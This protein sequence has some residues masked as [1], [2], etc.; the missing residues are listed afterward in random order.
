M[1]QDQSD[2]IGS[3][4]LEG[5]GWYEGCL[6]KKLEEEEEG[7]GGERYEFTEEQKSAKHPIIWGKWR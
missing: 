3:Q 1:K 7:K 4:H 2:E 6:E 5:R